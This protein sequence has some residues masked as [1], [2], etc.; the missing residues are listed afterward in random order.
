MKKLVGLLILAGLLTAAPVVPRK[1]AEF[2]I[3]KT[4]GEQ[5][6]LSAYRGKPVVLALMYATCS[7]CQHTAGLLNKISKDYS[8]K[9]V[10]VLGAVFNEGDVMRSDAFNKQFQIAFPCG[11]SNG[12]AVTSFLQWSPS[13]PYYVPILVF[14][15]KT[16]MIRKQVI[17]DE[18][19]L[20]N[21]TEEANIRAEIDKLLKPAVVSSAKKSA[22]SE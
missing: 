13:E 2:V 8:A 18:K 3:Q 11:Y 4:S 14:I 1:A 5:L 21:A 9:G 12:L 6:L 22:K 16:G 15:D 17:G 10:Q 20:D 7:H 19:F